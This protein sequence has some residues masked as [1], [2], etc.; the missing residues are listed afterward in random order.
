MTGATEKGEAKAASRMSLGRTS[1]DKREFL[2][3]EMVVDLAADPAA[4]A[5][6]TGD[7]NTLTCAASGGGGDNAECFGGK[8][9][10]N[11]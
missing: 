5:G 9:I 6:V 11:D 7:L 3:L 2:L 1:F 10:G 8:A 4:D